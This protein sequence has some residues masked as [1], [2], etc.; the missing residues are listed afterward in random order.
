[1]RV[2]CPLD[3]RSKHDC[4][5]LYQR[6]STSTA[7]AVMSAQTAGAIKKAREGL[8]CFGE[9]TADVILAVFILVPTQ[10]VSI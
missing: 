10:D 2:A 7:A 4:L 1:M 8:V 3:R 6:R 9:S 5:R